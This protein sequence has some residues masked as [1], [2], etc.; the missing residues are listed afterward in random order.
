MIVKLDSMHDR[1]ILRF[2]LFLSL[3]TSSSNNYSILET[4]HHVSAVT[5]K[6]L[7]FIQNYSG[8][9]IKQAF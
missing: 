2:K 5:G 9:L 4:R 8:T 3:V 1:L 7:N 6:E